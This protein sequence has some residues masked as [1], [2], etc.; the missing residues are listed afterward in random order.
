[1]GLLEDVKALMT[2]IS[3]IHI[4]NMPDKP[5]NCVALYHDGGT[6]ILSGTLVGEL[7]F[8]VRVRNKSYTAGNAIAKSVVEKL[9]GVDNNG[10]FLLIAETSDIMD[11][12]RDEADRQE[13][14]IVFRTYYRG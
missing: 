9:H 7:G 10:K 8:V 13:W 14:T 6:R 4:G 12:G 5:D 1:M 3:G 11:I 2:G